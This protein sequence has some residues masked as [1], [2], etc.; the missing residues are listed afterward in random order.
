MRG[1]LHAWFKHHYLVVNASALPES[2]AMHPGK[3]GLCCKQLPTPRELT[4]P[5]HK[6]FPSVPQSGLPMSSF[7]NNAAYNTSWLTGIYPENWSLLLLLSWLVLSS[8]APGACSVEHLPMNSPWPPHVLTSSS[9][10][11]IQG[12]KKIENSLKKFLILLL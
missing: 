6:R 9:C 12:I 10:G 8:L 5:C 2:Q 4:C 1:C 7:V 11:P 3:N